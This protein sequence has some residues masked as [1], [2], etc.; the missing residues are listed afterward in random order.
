MSNTIGIRNAYAESRKS[1]SEQGFI[2]T[3][4][5]LP[6]AL[7]AATE[8]GSV[9]PT[10]KRELV[11]GYF[12]ASAGEYYAAQ[13]ARDLFQLATSDDGSRSSVN[14]CAQGNSCSAQSTTAGE[15]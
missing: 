9:D 8:D 12:A 13:S 6:V 10:E 4:N 7:D 2:V 3:E 14:R 15:G 5:E 11:E 1:S